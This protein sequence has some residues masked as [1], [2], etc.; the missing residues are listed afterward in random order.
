MNPGPVV[1]GW[2][3]YCRLQCRAVPVKDLK[4]VYFTRRVGYRPGI[5]QVNA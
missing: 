1:G 3:L 2:G 5:Q 4:R